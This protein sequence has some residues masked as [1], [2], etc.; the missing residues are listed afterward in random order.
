MYKKILVVVDMQNDFVTGCLGNE[1]TKSVLPKVVRKIREHGKEYDAIYVTKDIHF[2]N[3]NETL[4][5]QKLP[6]EHCIKG[7]KGANICKELSDALT[8]LKKSRPVR[9][10]EKHTFASKTLMDYLHAI[11]GRNTVIEFCGVC[12]DICVASNAI[13]LRAELPNNVIQVDAS[14]CAG[15]TP[16][17]H[18]NALS[19]MASCQIDIIEE[20]ESTWLN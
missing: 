5:G 18:D 16:L 9:F 17:S 14:C 6:V 19:T 12:T 1:E 20:N 8:E 15:T 2:D 7:T 13:C 3:Y 10:V 4:E 11:C